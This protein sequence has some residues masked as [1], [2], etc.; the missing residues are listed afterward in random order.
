MNPNSIEEARE[1]ICSNQLLFVSGGK[2][3]TAIKAPV[4]YSNLDMSSF[5]GFLEY[6]PSEYTFTALAGTRL[7]EID[8]ILAENDQFLP[9][10][11]PL[12]DR[13]G[14][15][16]GTVASGLSGPGRYRFGGI[17]DF[18]IG[19]NYLNDEGK[20]IHSGGKVVKNAAGFDIPKLM[21]GSCGS[22]GALVEVSMKVFP[23]PD[24]Y[25]SI[26]SEFDSIKDA[27]GKLGELTASPIEFY[28][29]DLTPTKS[30]IELI[31]RIGGNPKLFP[32]RIK[33]LEQFLANISIIDG[34]D[35]VRH[36]RD[37]RE[38]NWLSTNSNLVK[39]PLTPRQVPALEEFF[40]QN[41]CER[42]YSV[43]ANVAWVAW[44]EPIDPLDQ[45]LIRKGLS[46][47]AILGS[48]SRSRIGSEYAGSFY[49]R[50]KNALDPGGKW[51]E[52]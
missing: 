34:D 37:E 22:F 32:N 39:I 43:G 33:R 42:R 20:R 48:T 12:I 30:S 49:Q 3:K 29:L 26:R 4:K 35:E 13:G 6:E 27:L 40:V 5:S 1:I 24:E 7:D 15:I 16:G 52:V 25:I 23:R 21:V 46:G 45:F 31:I 10:D 17:R 18:I 2:S 11:P 28:C 44:P 47:R 8:A 36:W 50:I 19:V 38:F 41:D 9:F 14:T 51:A